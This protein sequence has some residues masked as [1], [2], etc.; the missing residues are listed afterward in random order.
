GLGVLVSE[1]PVR[2]RG[3]RILSGWLRRHRHIFPRGGS[4]SGTILSDSG[5]RCRVPCPASTARY[6]SRWVC[7][8]SVKS[9]ARRGAILQ[10]LSPPRV[11]DGPPTGG[12]GA[13]SSSARNL[14]TSPRW[15]GWSST[16]R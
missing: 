2:Y 1:Q 3:G 5:Q 7:E 6:P 12:R 10:R 16:P 14:S 13:P 4:G 9:V 15:T 11:G 8:V